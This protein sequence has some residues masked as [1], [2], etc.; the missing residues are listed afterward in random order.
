[1]AFTRKSQLLDGQF[2]NH[3]GKDVKRW[4]DTF[5]HCSCG[6]R[7]KVF[8]LEELSPRMRPAHQMGQP[9]LFDNIVV[10]GIAVRQQ[11]PVR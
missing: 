1:M 11:I 2:A 9:L 5:K 10:P 7:S 4:I 6:C 3:V 8:L